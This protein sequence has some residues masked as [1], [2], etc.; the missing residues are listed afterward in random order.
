MKLIASLPLP[1]Y[2]DANSSKIAMNSALVKQIEAALHA[3]AID[4]DIPDV[5]NALT[6][7]LLDLPY[8]IQ[9]VEATSRKRG[10]VLLE[11]IIH[12]SAHGGVALTTQEL[13]ASPAL[14]AM[15]LQSTPPISISVWSAGW[16]PTRQRE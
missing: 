9:D 15:S 1:T 10:K 2:P 5:S 13:I 6:N 12:E 8:K 11:A 4:V 7:Y 16:L 14:W 3:I